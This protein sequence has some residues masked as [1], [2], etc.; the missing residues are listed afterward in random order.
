MTRRTCLQFLLA[1]MMT[2]PSL[3]FALVS[4]HPKG[5]YPGPLPNELEPYRSMIRVVEPTFRTSRL[6]F[7]RIS[8]SV[9]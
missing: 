6:R 5:K 2:I 8:M 1:A 9:C 7:L 3:C 4:T